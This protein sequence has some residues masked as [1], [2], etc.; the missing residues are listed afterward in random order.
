M[1]AQY[2]PYL[3]KLTSNDVFYLDCSILESG[4]H[5]DL[6]SSSIVDYA[7]THRIENIHLITAGNA[8]MSLK[9]AIEHAGADIQLIN[10]VSRD[11]EERIVRSLISQNS[12]VMRFDLEKEYFSS[13]NIA[14]G[15]F[16]ATYIEGPQ[17]DTLIRSAIA[18]SPEYVALP[19]GSG[20]LFNCFYNYIREHR[21]STKIIGIVPRG[22]HPL[23]QHG[24]SDRTLAD[25]LYCEFMNLKALEKIRESL[26]YG[27]R[28]ID[29]NNTQI[30]YC[31]QLSKLLG[32][33][34]EPS[35]AVTLVAPQQVEHKKIVCVLT[36]KGRLD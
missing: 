20:E 5:K 6:R 13:A 9:K 11:L 15:S 4:T 34:L 36:G 35:G 24:T 23:S 7:V 26:L 8:G 25:K 31:L 27:H 29:I 28:I 12:Q 21:L 1:I 3:S 17:Y 10:I 33:D 14:E 16:D 2:S 19:I 18:I 22:N 32:M 30:A